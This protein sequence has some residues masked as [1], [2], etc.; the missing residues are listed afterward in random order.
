V[1][2]LNEAR[3][4]PLEFPV[5]LAMEPTSNHGTIGLLALQPSI[6][7]TCTYSCLTQISDFF[8]VIRNVALA[9]SFKLLRPFVKGSLSAHASLI[10][11]FN[12]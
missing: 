2:T 4:F 9:E 10:T 12:I 5:V 3:I 7:H 1:W 8:S 6:L 11:L